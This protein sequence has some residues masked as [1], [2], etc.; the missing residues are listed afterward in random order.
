MIKSLQPVLVSCSWRLSWP[1]VR[2][3]RTGRTSCGSPART[4]GRHMGCYGDPTC[5]HAARGRAGGQGDALSACLVVRAGLCAGAHGDHLGLVPVEQRWSAHALDG[6]AAGRD[7]VVSAVPAR[8]GVLLHEQQQRRLQLSPARQSVGRIVRQSPL[9]QSPRGTAV[10]R[11]LQLDQEPREPDSH[12]SAP[13][14]H[15]S[16]RRSACRHIIPTRRKCART[17]LS[18]TTR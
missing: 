15:R 13:T 2:P 4:T 12:S 3:Q 7:Q 9:A 11:G 16:E 14:D 17:G 18:I 5:P 8:S 10:L 6:A 1:A